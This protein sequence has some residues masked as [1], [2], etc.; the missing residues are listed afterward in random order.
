MRAANYNGSNMTRGGRKILPV[1]VLAIALAGC[2]SY[3]NPFASKTVGPPPEPNILP[4]NYRANLLNFLQ[5]ELANPSGVRDA[6][7]TE[8][9]LQP[10]GSES[11]YVVCLRYNARNGY[12]RYTGT[13]DYVAIYFHGGLTQYVPAIA[14]QC[15]NA[16]YL[17]FPEL[18]ALKRPGT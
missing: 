3:E 7:I 12:G 4:Q 16:A 6:Y 2:S 13:N 10:I 5:N 11:R 15:S 1:A 8:P 14:G 17:R 9:K 18:E